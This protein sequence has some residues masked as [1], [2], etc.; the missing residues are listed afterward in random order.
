MTPM[1]KL[2]LVIV[3]VTVSAY[4]RLAHSGLGCADWPACYGRIGVTQV[5]NPTNLVESRNDPALSWATPLHVRV[6]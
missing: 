2:I 3:L 5:A 4:L 6:R 1:K